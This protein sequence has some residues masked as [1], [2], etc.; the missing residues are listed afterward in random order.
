MPFL[1]VILPFAALVLAVSASAEPF[2]SG[3]RDAT[4]RIHS[5][6]TAAGP[7]TNSRGQYAML[8][9]SARKTRERAIV[10][11]DKGKGEVVLAQP[12]VRGKCAVLKNGV[13]Y[14]PSE[15]PLN[16]KRAIWAANGL[17][18]KPYRW[19]GG[20]RSFHD[21]GYDCSGTVSYALHHAGV[22]ET[23]M[24]S[25]GFLNYGERGAG[26]WI[27]VYSRRGHTFALIAGLRLDT[28]GSSE[29]DGPRWRTAP[30]SPSGF[31][32]RHPAGL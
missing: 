16:V 20:H 13:A 23:P 6:T 27:T 26:R 4:P 17:Q 3:S 12:T 22:L 1:K 19:G 9:Q 21:A 2:R 31:R 29:R 7:A 11:G 5:R 28:T 14:A 30:R 18:R 15:A 24:P 25:K 32:A 8:Q 10:R